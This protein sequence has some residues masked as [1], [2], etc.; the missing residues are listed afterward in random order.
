MI[1]FPKK[2]QLT[3]DLAIHKDCK[4]NRNAFLKLQIT[5]G[6]YIFNFSFKGIPKIGQFLLLLAF[7][8]LHFVGHAQQTA[9]TEFSCLH[10]GS[11]SI[12]TTMLKQHQRVVGY[13]VW[14]DANQMKTTYLM[15]KGK[16]R[17]VYARL[18]N[19]SNYSSILVSTSGNYVNKQRKQAIGLT[20]DNGKIINRMLDKD[21]DA[22][23]F[24]LNGQ[25]LVF[26]SNQRFS[27]PGL[28]DRLHATYDK[29][30]ILSWAQKNQSS[31]FQTHLLVYENALKITAS[32]N[33]RQAKRK[34]LATVYTKTKQKQYVLIYLQRGAYLQKATKKI[35]AYLQSKDLYVYSMINLDTGGNDILSLHP[36]IKTCNNRTIKGFM[37]IQ[38]ATNLLVFY[39]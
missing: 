17:N 11:S 7:C 3:R 15:D 21:M 9:F 20:V 10:K 2:Q 6:Q 30:R 31:I 19:A 38:T 12:T 27:I 18:K 8:F 35:L 28:A 39:P 26:N 1:L 33:I 14:M 25:L 34:F 29:A 4:I 13:A 32:G 5:G 24:T 23:V 16:Y 37:P 36:S 22:L